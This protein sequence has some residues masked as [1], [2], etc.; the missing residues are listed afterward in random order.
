MIIKKLI[1][2]LFFILIVVISFSQTVISSFTEDEIDKKL[3]TDPGYAGIII[4][5]IKNLHRFR[6]PEYITCQAVHVYYDIVWLPPHYPEYE[7]G[8]RDSG[9]IVIF[10]P[11]FGIVL[12]HFIFLAFTDFYIPI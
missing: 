8:W 11:Y 5:R 12:P 7:S 6:S 10:R 9:E 1:V 3:D 4:G 2:I